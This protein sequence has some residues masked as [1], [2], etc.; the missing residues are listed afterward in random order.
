MRLFQLAT[1]SLLLVPIATLAQH[2]SHTPS[3]PGD[4]GAGAIHSSPAPAPTP[5]RSSSSSSSSISSP[6]YS[7]SSSTTYSTSSSENTH[8][9]SVSHSAGS[10]GGGSASIGGSVNDNHHNHSASSPTSRQDTQP[11]T[12]PTRHSDLDRDTRHA[13]H[14]SHDATGAKEGKAQPVASDHEKPWPEQKGPSP[15]GHSQIEK[16]HEY[17]V[18]G[19]G[20]PAKHCDKEPCKTSPPPAQVS[21]RD[22]RLGSCK[23]GPCEPCPPGSHAG[24]YGTCVSYAAPATAAAAGQYGLA[25]AFDPQ[26]TLFSSQTT[27]VETDLLWAKEGAR[28]ACMRDRE[29]AQC[30]F[31]QMDED[32]ARQRCQMLFVPTGC[33]LRSP[34]CL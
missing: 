31:A 1:A 13:A 29:S 8:S 21:H 15:A 19:A 20:T 2:S 30:T 26:C 3:Q 10:P 12:Q 7:P 17:P 22:W 11:G 9:S 34:M 27:Q 14:E 6:H 24:K 32:M 23:E 33:N 18:T 4:G 16:T 25:S 5:D 28:S